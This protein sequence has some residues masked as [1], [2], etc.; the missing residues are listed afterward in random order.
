MQWLYSFQNK[1]L[2]VLL[3]PDSPVEESHS[4]G[5]R[6]DKGGPFFYPVSR[7]LGFYVTE[8]GHRVWISASVK[9]LL[10]IKTQA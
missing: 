4:L 2:A 8:V 6:A 5:H 1:K 3:S 10:P 7:L 9:L